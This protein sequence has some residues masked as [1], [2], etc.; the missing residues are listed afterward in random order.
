MG[1]RSRTVLTTVAAFVLLVTL[2]ELAKLVLPADGVTVGGT[3][4]LPRTD[5]GSMPHV[6][7]VLGRLAEP[8]VA[9]AAT[10]RTVG[11]AVASGALFT[12]GLAMGGLVLGG[13]LGVLLALVMQRFRLVERAALPYVVA[14]QTVPLI[15]IAPLVSGWGG[16]IAI[17]GWSWQPWAS[18]MVISSYLAFFPI[19]VGMLRGLTSPARA[20]VELF[21]TLASGWWTTLVRLRLPAS[22]PHVVPAIRLAAAAAVVGAIVAEISTGTRGGIGRLIIEYAQSATGD[23]SRM[24]TAI[25]GAAVLGLVAAGAVGLLDV[26]LRRYRGSV[27]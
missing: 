1:S 8:E 20:D 13:V 3:R 18:V 6:S 19:A 26:G 23:P 10:T 12:L 17:L 11:A 14:S 2:W 21:R 9:G 22:V 16:N 24:Y 5:D 15:A 25:L 4:V 27:S 7:T